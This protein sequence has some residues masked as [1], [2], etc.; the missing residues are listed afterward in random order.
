MIN[1]K[2]HMKKSE[3]KQLI[4]EVI[5]EME[6]PWYNIDGETTINGNLYVYYAAVHHYYGER[7]VEVSQ[8]EVYNLN[9]PANDGDNVKLEE[10]PKI[11][12]SI[13]DSVTEEYISS[14]YEDGT[15][16][17]DGKDMD[18]YAVDRFERYRKGD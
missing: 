6:K 12:K 16:N 18:T 3:L 13:E 4:K 15:F 9:D 17:D 8:L 7:D 2:N 11:L 14:R 5:Q 10:D 1:I